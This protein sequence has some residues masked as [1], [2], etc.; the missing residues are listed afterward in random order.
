MSIFDG[1][2]RIDTFVEIFLDKMQ[3]HENIGP[4]LGSAANWNT[5]V[6]LWYQ[7]SLIKGYHHRIG[8]VVDT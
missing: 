1:Y 7:V 8:L 4:I 5:P 6:T 2:I 3:P